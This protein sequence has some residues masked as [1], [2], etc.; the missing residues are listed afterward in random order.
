[1]E[2]LQ[3]P[4]FLPIPPATEVIPFSSVDGQRTVI[5]ER[6]VTPDGCFVRATEGRE[7]PVQAFIGTTDPETMVAITAQ[8][9]QRALGNFELEW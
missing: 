9:A 1:M 5:M 6:T 2:S 4:Q 8:L 7:I 3:G